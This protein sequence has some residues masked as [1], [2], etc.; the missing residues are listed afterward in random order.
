VIPPFP[1]GKAFHVDSRLF[2][3]ASALAG[4]TPQSELRLIRAMPWS[5]KGFE[6]PRGFQLLCRHIAGLET[7]HQL[8]P[9]VV[10]FLREDGS[11][12]QRGASRV[13]YEGPQ[14][15]IV[16]C[17]SCTIKV[18]PVSAIDVEVTAHRILDGHVNIRRCLGMVRMRPNL[19]PLRA[20]LLEG[21]GI[22]LTHAM[23]HENFANFFKGALT[24]L[25]HIHSTGCVHRDVKLANMVVIRDKLVLN[26][27]ETV[28]RL[29]VVINK[30]VG[31]PFYSFRCDPTAFAPIHDIYSLVVSFAEPFIPDFKKVPISS[32]SGVI[33]RLQLGDDFARCVQECQSQGVL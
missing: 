4:F 8:E 33:E 16:E 5:E 23:V 24:A 2:D 15:M 10:S 29:P 18:A 27:F 25:Q 7:L 31:T 3:V 13:V 20:I 1:T 28:S 19:E 12:V 9:C 6:V 22:P 17:E 11:F 14:S 30:V 26:D 21:P 32:R